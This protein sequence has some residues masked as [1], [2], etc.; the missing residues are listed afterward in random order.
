MAISFDKALSV[1]DDALLLRSQRAE[2]LANNLTNADT[3]GFKARDIDFHAVLKNEV[4]A[5]QQSMAMATSDDKHF[6]SQQGIANSNL[7][8]LYRT[9]SMPSV[10]GNTV[11]ANVEQAEFMQN[12]LGFQTTFSFLNSRLKGMKSALTGE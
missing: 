9:P 12:S 8:P 1:H 5:Q 10:D 2:I 6:N 3:P 7:Q 11:D 4:T